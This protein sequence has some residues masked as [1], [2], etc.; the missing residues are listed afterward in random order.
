MGII[1][2]LTKLVKEGPCRDFRRFG[3]VDSA[4][5]FSILVGDVWLRFLSVV[6]GLTMNV[7][8]TGR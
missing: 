8:F 4:P 1:G 5:L 6:S 3:K 7:G 2:L